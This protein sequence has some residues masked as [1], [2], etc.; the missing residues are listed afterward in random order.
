M[1]V[2]EGL[3]SRGLLGAKPCMCFFVSCLYPFCAMGLLYKD[4]SNAV[5]SGKHHA[6]VEEPFYIT[7]WV[8]VIY[9]DAVRSTC[10]FSSAEMF[11]KVGTG[12][13]TY[14]ELTYILGS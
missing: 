13:D 14:I 2:S 11:L 10:C 4:N 9:T 1:S 3:I 12:K 6:A 7:N 5:I 8:N